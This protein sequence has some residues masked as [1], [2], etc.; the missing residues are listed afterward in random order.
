MQ[1]ISSGKK[2]WMSSA[3]VGEKESARTIRLSVEISGQAML[4]AREGEGFKY[5]RA[6]S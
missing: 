4:S 6:I 3:A 2:S 1:C 5:V